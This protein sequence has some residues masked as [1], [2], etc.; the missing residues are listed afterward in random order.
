MMSAQLFRQPE[1]LPWPNSKA[2][3]PSELVAAIRDERPKRLLKQ[4]RASEQ[5]SMMLL[6]LIAEEFTK[7]EFNNFSKDNSQTRG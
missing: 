7:E 4:Y 6:P 3:D 2:D 5:D 1:I